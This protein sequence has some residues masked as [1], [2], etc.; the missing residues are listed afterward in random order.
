M[1]VG[2]DCVLK[3]NNLWR[4]VQC[5]SVSSHIRR[6]GTGS[7][8]SWVGVQVLLTKMMRPVLQLILLAIFL[9]FFGLPA[10]ETFGQKKVIVEEER[11]DTNGIPCPAV[12]IAARTQ[13]GLEPVD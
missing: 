7:M 13:N 4:A 11:R 2:S 10:I 3:F 12:T 9:F 8:Y 5:R 6:A 1:L